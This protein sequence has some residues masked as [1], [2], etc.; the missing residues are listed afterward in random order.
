MDLGSILSVVQG[1]YDAADRVNK[2]MQPTLDKAAKQLEYQQKLEQKLQEIWREHFDANKIFCLPDDT[3]KLTNS[4]WIAQWKEKE[5]SLFRTIRENFYMKSKGWNH[6]LSPPLNKWQLQG[7][8][9]NPTPTTTNTED[10]TTPEGILGWL[11]IL[12]RGVGFVIYIVV[13]IAF[14]YLFLKW[15]GLI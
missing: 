4:Y 13:W 12:A 9:E 10:Y 5:D 6:R 11:T 14:G 2:S 8:V 1:V 15:R 3:D 7:E